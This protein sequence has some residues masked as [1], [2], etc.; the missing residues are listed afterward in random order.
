MLIPRTAAATVAHL[1]EGYPVVAITGP[2]QSGKTTLARAVFAEKPYV[3]LEDLD[4]RELAQGDPRRFL[5]RFPD[6]AILDEVQRTPGLFSYLQ[7]R[8]DGDSRRGLFI[9]TGSQQFD[10]LAN[11]TQTLAGRVAL[12][13]LLPFSLGELQ[14]AGEAPARLEQLLFQGLYPPIYDRDLEPGI[15]YS[16]YVRTYVERDVRQMVNVRDLSAFQRFVRMCA[17]RTGQLLN[18][19]GLAADCGITH[20]TAGAWLS[21]LE[22]SYI[23]HLLQPHHSN[24]GKRLVK[25]PKLYFH[26]PG[27]ATWLLGIQSP[28]QLA[29]HAQRG[30][31]FE[32]WVVAELL[33][34][35]FHRALGSNLTFWRDKSGHEVDV[36]IEE[37]SRLI[38]VEIKSGQTVT[39]DSFAGLEQ[40]MG[41]AGPTA[42]R[43]WLV[44]GGDTRQS[45]AV[46]EVVPWREIGSVTD[47]G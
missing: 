7:T 44:Y 17:A 30:A 11:V 41:L 36:L 25:T 32:T 20:H 21:V 34:A 31:L 4:E 10:L 19:S 1:A 37:G 33:K 18:L 46:A 45:R 42:G 15:W 2:R 16:N 40:W 14:A 9:L 12:V 29:T 6:G 39:A 13:S 27:L 23:V 22:A 28:E 5:D 26:D 38:P 8:V 24:L 3:S 47:T 35:R 43:P